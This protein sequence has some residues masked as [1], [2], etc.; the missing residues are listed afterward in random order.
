MLITINTLSRIFLI[1]RLGFFTREYICNAEQIPEILKNELEVNDDFVI[2][3]IVGC[4]MKKCSRT[5]LN[6]TFKT[7]KIDFKL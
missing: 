3:E 5:A 6:K 2:Y 4:K 7:Q 1:Q